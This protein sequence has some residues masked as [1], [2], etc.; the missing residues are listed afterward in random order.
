MCIPDTLWQATKKAQTSLKGG[1]NLT[2]FL[3]GTP[4]QSWFN[5]F[6]E[7]GCWPYAGTTSASTN[8]VPEQPCSV[9]PIGCALAKAISKG[10]PWFLFYGSITCLQS[11]PCFFKNFQRCLFSAHVGFYMTCIIMTNGCLRACWGQCNQGQWGWCLWNLECD[12]WR[13]WK[14]SSP[15]QFT[16]VVEKNEAPVWHWTFQSSFQGTLQF[17]ASCW[18]QGNLCQHR[19]ETSSFLLPGCDWMLISKREDATTC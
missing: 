3:R 19:V 12:L 18:Y 1:A 11:P 10:V 2:S 4:C 15:W 8:A 6:W 17:W 5:R 16:N 13:T 7:W 9:G 14:T